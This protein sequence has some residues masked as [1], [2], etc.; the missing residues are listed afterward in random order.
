[1]FWN[2]SLFGEWNLVR[3]LLRRLIKKTGFE[4]QR[5]HILK[6]LKKKRR[7][8]LKAVIEDRF[9]VVYH[10]R[11][12]SRLYQPAESLTCGPIARPD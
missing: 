7:V 6:A 11:S 1:M 10:E 4:R 2:N 9:G 5:F 3:I 8:D 12:V